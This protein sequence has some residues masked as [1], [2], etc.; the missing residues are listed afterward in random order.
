MHDPVAVVTPVAV[1]RGLDL[2]LGILALLVALLTLAPAGSGGWA[3]GDPGTELR[4][5]LT[6]LG[7]PATTAQLVGNLALL[8]PAAVL[9]VARWPVL[10]SVGL[11]WRRLSR[12]AGASSCCS[13]SCR[14]AG[15][16]PR[17]TPG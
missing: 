17:S 15:W 14:W 13:G 8:G 5:Y 6:G 11:S 2:G 3:W 10:R 9:A 4:W 16:C 1:R 12:A 7:D